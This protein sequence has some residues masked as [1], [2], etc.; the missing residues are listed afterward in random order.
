MVRK[1]HDKD[2]VRLL[3]INGG[4]GKVTYQVFAPV[5]VSYICAVRLHPVAKYF[6]SEENLTQQTT[7]ENK[8]H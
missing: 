1:A 2:N 5:F 7:L 6:P 4:Q 3:F 8:L